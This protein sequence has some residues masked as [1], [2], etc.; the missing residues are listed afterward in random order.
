MELPH[1]DL[2]PYIPP[3]YTILCANGVDVKGYG[4]EVKAYDADDKGHNGL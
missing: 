1:P 4:V 2:T 3:L